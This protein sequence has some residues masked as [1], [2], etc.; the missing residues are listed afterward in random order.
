M[1]EFSHGELSYARLTVYKN[2]HA[3]IG[4]R[5]DVERVDRDGRLLGESLFQTGRM[6]GARLTSKDKRILESSRVSLRV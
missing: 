2:A 3:L 6:R 1:D 5:V 4:T